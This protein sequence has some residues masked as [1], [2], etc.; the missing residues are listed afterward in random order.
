[1]Q[2][3]IN[4]ILSETIGIHAFIVPTTNNT[5]MEDRCISEV[6]TTLAP[7]NVD[8]LSFYYRGGMYSSMKSVFI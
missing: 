2:M 6:G 3:G 1:M 4:A 8:F 7:F 5:N